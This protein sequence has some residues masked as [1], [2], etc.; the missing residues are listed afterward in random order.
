MSEKVQVLQVFNES[1]SIFLENHFFHDSV[2]SRVSQF[3]MCT[4]TLG[5]LE[6]R[7]G[8]VKSTPGCPLSCGKKGGAE[9]T[10]M[11]HLRTYTLS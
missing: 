8:P 6:C 10:K 9:T 11:D 3:R 4:F 5:I 7:Q 1:P 2:I